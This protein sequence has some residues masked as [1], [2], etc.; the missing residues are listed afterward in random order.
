MPRGRGN[1]TISATKGRTNCS[2][3]S[4]PPSKV[5]TIIER[6]ATIWTRHLHPLLPVTQHRACVQFPHHA[7]YPNIRILLNPQHVPSGSSHPHQAVQPLHQ[8]LRIARSENGRTG[9]ARHR[10]QSHHFQNFQRIAARQSQHCSQL[11]D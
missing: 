11:I 3:P 5:T 2:T 1:G 7:Q 10:F 4:A 6:I 9:H 8:A